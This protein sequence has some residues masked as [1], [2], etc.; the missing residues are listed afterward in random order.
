MLLSMSVVF[1]IIESRTEGPKDT[2]AVFEGGFVARIQEE[3]RLIKASREME[4]QYM[5]L[6][7]LIREEREEGNAQGKI[8]SILELLSDLGEI[9]EDIRR[10]VTE[11][12]DPE[13]LK[14]YLKQASAA[15]TME[16]FR[17]AAAEKMRG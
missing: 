4:E 3:I 2:T 16:A 5:L 8:S 1:F 13:V 6:E 7:E 17:Q 12:R 14:F 9:P 10:A 11:E 15:N